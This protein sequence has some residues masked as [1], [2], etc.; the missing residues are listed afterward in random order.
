MYNLEIRKIIN[1]VPPVITPMEESMKKIYEL[2]HDQNRNPKPDILKLR[3]ME[4]NKQL[5]KD[6]SHSNKNTDDLN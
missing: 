2:E 4:A 5:K 3:E 1:Q 6:P